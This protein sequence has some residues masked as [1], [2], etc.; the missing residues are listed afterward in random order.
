MRRSRG[1]STFVGT[2]VLVS[3][4]LSLSYVVYEGVSRLVPTRQF[5]FVNNMN[6]LPGNPSLEQVSVDASSP[7]TPSALA[8]DNFSSTSGIL[9]FDGTS[10]GTTQHLCSS[11]ATTFFSVYTGSGTLQAKA[12]GR[13]WIDG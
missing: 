9:Y 10:Y 1:V 11:G 12:N 2:L 3:I 6:F 8:I 5:V 13:A 4:S 7:A